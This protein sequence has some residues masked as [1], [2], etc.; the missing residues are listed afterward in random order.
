MYT[1]ANYAFAA[2]LFSDAQIAMISKTG[3]PPTEVTPY[4][5]ISLMAVMAKLF[6]RLF[7]SRLEEAVP[8]KLNPSIQI[9]LSWEPLAQQCHK[10]INKIRDCLEDKRSV[11]QF[12]LL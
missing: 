9:R 6:E 11:L 8:L 5:P 10:I 4:R 2:F 7:L 12:F 3:K 1:K